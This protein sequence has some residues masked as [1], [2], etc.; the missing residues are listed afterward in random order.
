M[1]VTL[2]KRAALAQQA[3]NLIYSKLFISAADLEKALSIATPT[4][5][6]IIRLL[7]ENNV[8]HEV[9]GLRRG[10]IYVFRRYFQLFRS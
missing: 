8:L 4:A 9:T 3:L 10:K 1:T 7:I 5:N 2:G 6:S